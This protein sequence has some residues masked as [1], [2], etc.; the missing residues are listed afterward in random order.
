MITNG[1]VG[2][3]PSGN[4]GVIN[5]LGNRPILVVDDSEDDRSLLQHA[6]ESFLPLDKPV[7]SMASGHDV[8]SY[9]D[10]LQSS[11]LEGRQFDEEVP[12]MVFLDLL[13]PGMNG[14]DVLEKIRSQTIWRDMPITLVTCSKNNQAVE[15]AQDYGANAFLPKP[16]TTFDVITTFNR[17]NNFAPTI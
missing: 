5:S 17:A 15:Q 16:F 12:E 8:L 13:M 1:T 4:N 10:V 7:I 6:L 2:V 14:I 3:E 11:S 9:L